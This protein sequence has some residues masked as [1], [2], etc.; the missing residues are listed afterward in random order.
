MSASRN[1]YTKA[2]PR[3]ECLVRVADYCFSK[4]NF[5]KLVGTTPHREFISRRNMRNLNSSLTS[6]KGPKRSST[7]PRDQPKSP[8]GGP[9]PLA[10]KAAN[11]DSECAW[12][13]H[14]RFAD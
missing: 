5:Q 9:Q 14:V 8:R 10:K 13:E 12:T 2:T 3:D 4:F 1:S 7:T 6:L 11:A